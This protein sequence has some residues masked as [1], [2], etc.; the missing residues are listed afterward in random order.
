M[1]TTA[2]D[3]SPRGVAGRTQTLDVYG[4]S[5]I[6]AGG[7]RL[8]YG[9]SDNIVTPCIPANATALTADAVASALSSANS[10]LNVT[11]DEDDPP[12]D[13]A[14]RFVVYF[15]APEVGVGV[16]GVIDAEDD[17]D[18]DC[19]WL[20]CW[21]SSDGDGEDDD[22]EEEGA[23]DESG[24]LVNR[25]MSVFVEE[26]AVEVRAYMARTWGVGGCVVFPLGCVV[27]C[28]RKG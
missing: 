28:R 18:G 12:F 2:A 11:V 26:G 14:R 17:D 1:S 25:E 21:S 20:Q 5:T 4:S 16:L 9:G 22:G 23:C 13:G 24:V 3:G 10:F 6:T 7:F 27:V 19:E 8:S 15:H